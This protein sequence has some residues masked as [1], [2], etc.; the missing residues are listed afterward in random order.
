MENEIKL[1]A[2]IGIAAGMIAAVLNEYQS[3]T[4]GKKSVDDFIPGSKF[5]DKSNKTA[6]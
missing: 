2:A 4:L 1:F 6:Q 5:F 3:L